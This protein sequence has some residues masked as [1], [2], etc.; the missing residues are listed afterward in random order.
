[1]SGFKEFKPTS[2]SIDNKTSIY[3][4]LHKTTQGAIPGYRYPHH[5]RSNH[6]PRLLSQGYRE[7]DNQAH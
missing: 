6:L 2:W 3:F 1:M 4:I 5:L 7:P